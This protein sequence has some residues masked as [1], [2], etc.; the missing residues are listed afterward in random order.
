MSREDL[1]SYLQ[2][3]EV[4]FRI[5]TFKKH[6]MTVE[7][8]ERQLGVSRERI[9]KSLLF[10]DENGTP[11]LGIVTGDR[12]ISDKK[13]RKACGARKLKLARPSVV[14]EITGYE[15]GALPPIIHGKPIRA[16]IDPKVMSF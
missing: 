13:L 4:K 12:R 5:L 14:K 15:V 6:T 3:E 1:E 10:I 8:A 2:S 16:F 9:V 7:D 11:I